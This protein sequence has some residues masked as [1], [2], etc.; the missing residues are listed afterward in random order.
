MNDLMARAHRASKIPSLPVLLLVGSLLS[1]VGPGLTR[2]VS[3]TPVTAQSADESDSPQPIRA[4]IEQGHHEQAEKLAR[5]LLSRVE[6]DAGAESLE[7][8][9][10][11]DALVEALMKGG[12][13]RE[14]ETRSL[15]ER[16]L[17]IK[18]AR[19][20]DD[21]LDVA[22]SLRALGEILLK[23]GDYGAARAELERALAIQES[24]L[25]SNALSVATTLTSLSNVIYSAGDHEELERIDERV[26][27]IRE[28]AL[29]PRHPDV[30]SSLNNLGL[31]RLAND[32]FAGAE[33]LFLRALAI[34]LE[35]SGPDHADVAKV[36]NNL[37][38]LYKKTGAYAQARLHLER[39]LEIKE[40]AHGSNHP[41]LVR[42]LAILGQLFRNHGD[43]EAARAATERGLAIRESTLGARH[44]LVAAMLTD[45]GN[46]RLEM[47]DPKAAKPL[48]E[49]ALAIWEESSEGD[50]PHVAMGLHNL[51]NVLG[52]LKDYGR[53]RA[54]LE[55][56]ISITEQY[57]GPDHTSLASALESL[58]E[59]LTRMGLYDE[60]RTRVDRALAIL[61]EKLG[62]DHPQLAWALLRRSFLELAKG[63]YAAAAE[64][65]MRTEELSRR[66]LRVT[67]QTLSER[68]ALSYAAGRASGLGL[69]LSIV[70][71]RPDVSPGL[72]AAALDSVVR[73]RALV[74]D[75]MVAR[76][77]QLRGA[78][79]P[80]VAR[81]SEELTAARQKLADLLVHGPS[82]AKPDRYQRDLAD[83][84]RAK[85]T[86]EGA[87][88]ASSARYRE[89]SD[90]TDF[91]GQA[92]RS[93][94]PPGSALVS[95]VRYHRYE[96]ENEN[97]RRPPDSEAVP[98]YLAFV[99]RQGRSQPAM[100][101]LGPSEHIERAVRDWN[102]ELARESLT[103][104]AD[105]DAQETR[106][107]QVAAILRRAIWDPVAKKLEGATLVFLVPDGALHH[108]SFATLPKGRASYLL[109][110]APILHYL[111][112]ERDLSTSDH[113][114]AGADGLLAMGGP[115][116][117]EMGLFATLQR[118]VEPPT[119]QP[120]LTSGLVP[121]GL[122]SACGDFRSLRFAPLPGSS[123]EVQ[124]VAELWNNQVVAPPGDDLDEPDESP[125]RAVVLTGA[126]ATETAFKRH[127]PG[128]RI[129][130]LATHGFFLGDRC[131]SALAG[132]RGIWGVESASEHRSTATSGEN[133]L[134]LSG[135][136]FAGANYRHAAAAEED[137]GI[138]TA[139]EIAGLD[140]SGVE[141]AVLSACDTALGEIQ[142]G[143]GVLGLRRAFRLA[144]AR[145]LIMSLWSVDDEAARAWMKALYS[146]RLTDRLDTARSVRAASLEV[147]NARRH[148][149]RSTHPFYWGGFV[150]AGDW[151]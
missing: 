34:Y 27:A 138:L 30:A 74:M 130:H 121:Q 97:D 88:A 39:A 24:Q 148:Q 6:A 127:A 98:S 1:A 17:R 141:W 107:R 16:A 38:M 58:A 79:E 37:G 95:Y 116:Y 115:S 94:L 111:S 123:L 23:T 149:D 21:H 2:A 125:S 18:R 76:N 41:A 81:L 43:Y 124:E 136:A 62:P 9:H 7:L 140:L 20:G 117:D 54:L 146:A 132:A 84:R 26:L 66:H 31:T 46:L 50:G 83:A 92:L 68:E 35:S 65:A 77:L 29:G 118:Q 139:D 128:R 22:D 129:L 142:A 87:L 90:M 32:D 49:R 67:A 113:V 93:A 3:A 36:H 119:P 110:E 109:D 15:A 14:P 72:R 108:V 45:L 102:A 48:L 131:P 40:R 147:L 137:D 73:S 133:P 82:D 78:S 100:I 112:A 61:L 11:I 144:G 150:A 85:Q 151:R 91:G 52:E 122:R 8:A 63:A 59:L 47:G 71:G 126:T 33:P 143:E 114:S 42:T 28:K 134:W 13:S 106:Y 105:S 51:A 101:P 12:K 25:G 4:L 70:T 56:S 53:A 99:L 10:T 19:L 135:L 89:L 104:E 55:R 5:S 86:A 44:P 69:L 60:A 75:E 80:E 64:T 103:E 120:L 96:L 145:S 57:R